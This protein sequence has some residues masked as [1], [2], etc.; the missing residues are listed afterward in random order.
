MKRGVLRG[1]II[2]AIVI[3]LLSMSVTVFSQQVSSDR[4]PNLAAAQ[5]F[6]QSAIDK[7]TAAQKANNYDMKGHAARAKDLLSQAYNEV[8]L[9][10]QAAN[11]Q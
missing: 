11:G 4:H 7:V 1:L 8:W 9:A 5:Q 2:G 3:G 6:I 10:A